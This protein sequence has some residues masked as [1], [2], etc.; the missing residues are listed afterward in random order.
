MEEIVESFFEKFENGKT[1]GIFS[2]RWSNTSLYSKENLIHSRH[3]SKYKMPPTLMCLNNS[4]RFLYLA[5]PKIVIVYQG[6]KVHLFCP[7]LGFL[8]E[9][10]PRLENRPEQKAKGNF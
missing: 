9:A 4:L 8:V 10:E 7:S 2:A 3:Q 5:L 1:R 6:Q